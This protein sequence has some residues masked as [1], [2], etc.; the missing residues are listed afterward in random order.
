MGIIAFNLPLPPSKND[1]RRL[2]TRG[3]K[4]FPVLSSVVNKYRQDV[5]L[6]IGRFRDWVKD[7]HKIVVECTWRKRSNN[8]D[9]A[10][11][12]DELLDAICPVLGFNDKWALVRDI[13]FTVDSRDPGVHVEVWALSDFSTSPESEP[14]STSDPD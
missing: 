4:T 13:D 12:H 2:I 10:N 9:C 5:G 6:L 8:Q 7:G 3:G 14:S 11:F 1:R